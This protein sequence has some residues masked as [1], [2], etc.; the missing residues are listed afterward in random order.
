M[1]I[2]YRNYMTHHACDAHF[3]VHN[4]LV[5]CAI[6]YVNYSYCVVMKSAL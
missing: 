2:M 4:G 6:V 1:F 3:I 5:L